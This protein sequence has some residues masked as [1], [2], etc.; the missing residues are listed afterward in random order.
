MPDPV[1]L[2]MTP[3]PVSPAASAPSSADPT[4][5]GNIAT[6]H[7]TES[8]GSSEKINSIADLKNKS[9]K[10]WNAMLMGIAQNICN[11]MREHMD[12]L[13]EMMREGRRGGG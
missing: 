12:R 4:T 1:N 5:A 13:R 8:S 11:E 9:P 10:L 3:S 6:V 7:G 2:S